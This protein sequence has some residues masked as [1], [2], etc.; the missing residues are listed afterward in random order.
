MAAI[1]LPVPAN[2]Q[3]LNDMA[4]QIQSLNNANGDLKNRLSQFQ[5]LAAL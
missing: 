5:A 3:E 2:Q 1:T 4:T